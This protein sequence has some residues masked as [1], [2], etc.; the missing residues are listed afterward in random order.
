[1]ISMY[2]QYIPCIYHDAVFTLHKKACG[3]ICCYDPITHGLSIARIANSLS[4]K[5]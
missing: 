4:E 3:A 2:R 1:M 5:P